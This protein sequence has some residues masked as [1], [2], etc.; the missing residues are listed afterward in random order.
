MDWGCFGSELLRLRADY[1]VNDGSLDPSRRLFRTLAYKCVRR[2]DV[3]EERLFRSLKSTLTTDR[4]YSGKMSERR[5]GRIDSGVRLIHRVGLERLGLVPKLEFLATI[6]ARSKRA[7]LK[8]S[9]KLNS[10][11]RGD[12]SRRVTK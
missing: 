2:F 1:F 3:Q 10:D 9:P 8:R 5:C 6:L 7:I 12:S 4:K 11:F